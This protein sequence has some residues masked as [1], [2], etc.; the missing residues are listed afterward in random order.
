VHENSI[1]R[2][3]AVFLTT[4]FHSRQTWVQVTLSEKD[5]FV[6]IATRSSEGHFNITNFVKSKKLKQRKER[7]KENAL[8]T[9]ELKCASFFDMHEVY[10]ACIL[11]FPQGTCVTV[12][13][14]E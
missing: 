2:N 6:V 1:S 3:K 5:K 13:T 10:G 4:E 9:S 8:W 12:C 14:V 11:T 7:N